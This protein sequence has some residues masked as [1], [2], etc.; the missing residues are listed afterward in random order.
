MTKLMMTACFVFTFVMSSAASAYVP[1]AKFILDRT[2]KGRDGL[3]TL[4]MGFEIEDV[5]RVSRFQETLRLDFMTAKFWSTTT[6]AQGGLM[7]SASG[8]FKDLKPMGRAWVVLAYDPSESRFREWSQPLQ[9]WPTEKTEVRL[10][11]DLGKAYWSWGKDAQVQIQKDQFQ[12]GGFTDS[13]MNQL[14]VKD[15]AR[16]PRVIVLRKKPSSSTAVAQER[17]IATLKSFKIN[18]QNKWIQQ[19]P[20]APHGAQVDSVQEWVELVR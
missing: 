20:I 15:Q 8:S 14:L 16:F 3:K 10:T 13:Q 17:F 11:R 9:L 7:S 12:F 4:E 5:S 18:P 19:Q 1:P 2:L 6:D